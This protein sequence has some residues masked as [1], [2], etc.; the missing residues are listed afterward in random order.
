MLTGCTTEGVVAVVEGG[1]DGL[2]AD[3]TKLGL[4]EGGGFGGNAGISG[5][6]GSTETLGRETAT[7]GGGGR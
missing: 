4:L 5:L 3:P 1:G 7:G 2:T 6:G